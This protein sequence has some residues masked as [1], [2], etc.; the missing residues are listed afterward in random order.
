ML[1]KDYYTLLQD[2]L[3][4]CNVSVSKILSAFKQ[5]LEV[6]SF[7]KT[8]IRSKF[9]ISDDT[10]KMLIERKILSVASSRYEFSVPCSG[11]YLESLCKG[12]LE[13]L[14]MLKRKGSHEILETE[15]V[16]IKLKHSKLGAKY[17][18]HDLIGSNSL[19]SIKCGMGKLIRWSK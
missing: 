6:Q 3:N 12:R 5:H 13:I 14:G 16:S 4:E 18:L 1:A 15:L 9:C 8:E 19:K 7:S 11:N 2:T 17:I 10:I